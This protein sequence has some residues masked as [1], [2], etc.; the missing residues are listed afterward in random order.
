MFA[1]AVDMQSTAYWVG[2]LVAIKAVSILFGSFCGSLPYYIAQRRNRPTFAHVALVICIVLS[3]LG[4]VLAVPASLTFSVAVLSYPRRRSKW[5][6]AATQEL[7]IVRMLITAALS[8][9]TFGLSFSL[10]YPLYVCVVRAYARTTNLHE[11]AV[12]VNKGLPKQIDQVTQCDRVEDGPDRNL[13]YFFTLSVDPVL[14]DK[15]RFEEVIT[16][17]ALALEDI[18]SMLE[19]G[20]TIWLKYRDKSGNTIHDIVLKPEMAKSQNASSAPKAVGQFKIPRTGPVVFENGALQQFLQKPNDLPRPAAAPMSPMTTPAAPNTPA[21]VALN[22]EEAAKRQK[23]QEEKRLAAEKAYQERQRQFEEQ[24]RR[25]EERIGERR[26]RTARALPSAV[27]SQTAEPSDDFRTWRDSTGKFTIEAKLVSSADG[28]VTLEK[29]DGSQVVIPL[30]RLC[31]ADRAFLKST[32]ANIAA[33][34]TTEAIGSSSGWTYRSEG[35]SPVLG[36]QYR[37]GSWGEEK[38]VAPIQ[39]VF[40]R[41][42]TAPGQSIVLARSGYAIGA[43]KVD[44]DRYV[45]AMQVVFMRLKSGRLDPNDSYTSDWIGFPTGREPKTISGSGSLVI[46]FYGYNGAVLGSIGLILRPSPPAASG[47]IVI[48]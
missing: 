22:A 26:N 1:Q 45:N 12:E 10:V 28:K 41:R 47:P 46:G 42:E 14:I 21:S 44:A 3:F 15:R 27:A 19:N 40:D 6:N 23:E 17:K 4:F 5:G 32:P 9:V 25:I 48:E 39:A 43:L 20:V 7:R 2:T 13:S 31:P 30:S 35:R 33:S 29:R 18:R 16:R 34:N 37:L 38:C 36:I 24:R 8:F 11:V